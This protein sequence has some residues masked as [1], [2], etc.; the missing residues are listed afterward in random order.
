MVEPSPGTRAGG[1]FETVGSLFA[2]VD[3]LYASDASSNR[4][5]TVRG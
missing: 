3:D 2:L 4:L 5:E 1:Y